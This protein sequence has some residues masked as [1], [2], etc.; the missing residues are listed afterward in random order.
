MKTLTREEAAGIKRVRNGKTSYAR[1]VLMAMNVGEV[2]L[3]EPQDWKQ[4]T[5]APST[6]C[7]KLTR[8]TGLAWVCDKALDGR[9][10]VVER[11]K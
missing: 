4:R 5:E 11:V 8:K 9:G 1:G 7:R 3:L 2:I 6:Y 10:W